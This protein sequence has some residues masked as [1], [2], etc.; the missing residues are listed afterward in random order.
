MKGYW[1]L[2]E[3]DNAKKESITKIFTAYKTLDE[4]EMQFNSPFLNA[5]KGG[6]DEDM[7][8]QLG[9]MT[10]TDMSLSITQDVSFFH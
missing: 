1:L 6:F 10:Y 9:I 4:H 3:D 2:S 7:L 8:K 5:P